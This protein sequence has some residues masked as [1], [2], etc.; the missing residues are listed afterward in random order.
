MI[1]SVTGEFKDQVSDLVKKVIKTDTDAEQARITLRKKAQSDFWFSCYHVYGF[2]DVDNEFHRNLC[3]RYQHRYNKLFSLWLE[4]RGHL[5]TTIITVGG[6]VW[7]A[8]Q[9]WIRQPNG[10]LI[11]GQDIR[12]LI[13]SAKI[14]S[15]VDII[16]DIETIFT[17]N[18][19]FGWLFPEYVPSE[20]WRRGRERGKWNASRLDWPNSRRAGRKEGNVTALSVGA[21]L[22]GK[23]VDDITLDDVVNDEN[24][25]TKEMR[26]SIDR[27]YLNLLQLRD[28]PSGS[29]VRLI[30]TRW[31]YDDQ[32]GRLIRREE[33]YRK[34]QAEAN[35]VVKPAYFIHR[36]K[37]SV[38]EQPLWPER[39]T[40]EHLSWL[41]SHLGS[42][43]YSCQYEND[44]VPEE[45]AH[46]KRNHIKRIAEIDLPGNLV[47]YV[48]TDLADEE[49]TRGDFTIITVASF[50]E[51]G[52]M[53]VRKIIR[54]R[55]SQYEF[56]RLVHDA[57][58]RWS[59]AKVGVETTGFQKSL[60]RGYKAE[61]EKNNWYIPWAELER[62]KTAKFKRH[63]GLQ[64][65]VERGDFYI[66]ED[67]EY[68]EDAIEEMVQCPKGTHDDILDTFA[69]LEHIHYSAPKIFI[70]SVP[71]QLTFEGAYGDITK[72]VV[73]D[74]NSDDFLSPNTIL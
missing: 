74:E 39:F 64:P 60:L 65:R 28:N 31:H 2:R 52:K 3:D 63:L 62:G 13:G 38:D 15:A 34:Q 18:D 69:D 36:T 72:L 25:T 40:Q 47:T 42:Y 14:D 7:Q 66:V 17:Q 12:F 30:G 1:E 37:A 20:A 58:V 11:R 9:D 43:I 16:R 24:I 8:T 61:V 41:K 49:T 27:W 19:M 54:G 32:Y 33:A 35:K 67:I 55:F 50:D 71:S 22:V 29:R 10:S 57:C 48:S 26:D 59:P 44:P 51:F 5:K 73:D 23:H 21:S 56:L 46:F 6:T 53:Y 4:P 45:D 70:E 68:A